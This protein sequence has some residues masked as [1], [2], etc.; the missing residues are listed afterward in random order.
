M[1]TSTSIEKDL[2]ELERKY[3]Q[4]IKDGDAEAAARLSDDPCVVTGAQGVGELSR[5]QL[6]GMMAG[7]KWKLEAFEISNVIVR[8]VTDDVA[9]VAYKVHEQLTF[10]GK[11]LTLDAADTSTWVRRNGS[12]VCA[13]HTESIAGD[14]FGRDRGKT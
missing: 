8:A 1:A 6:K 10:D 5:Q 9:T 3:W 2:L 4:A 13:V 7:S 11:P 14:P 12:W